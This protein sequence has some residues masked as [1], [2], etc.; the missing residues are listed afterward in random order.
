M[1][2]CM[3]FKPTGNR[4]GKISLL[5][6]FLTAL[7]AM[8]G[9]PLA[10]MAA[11]PAADELALV[12]GRLYPP[13]VLKELR[14]DSGYLVAGI[15]LLTPRDL[16]VSL[17]HPG[18]FREPSLLVLLGTDGVEFHQTA[19]EGRIHQVS[20][21][22][23]KVMVACST[24]GTI[25]IFDSSTVPI[26]SLD[27]QLPVTAVA[28]DTQGR[29]WAA[30]PL[31]LDWEAG[32]PYRAANRLHL[33]PTDGMMLVQFA[34][35][36]TIAQ[37][38]PVG[39]GTLVPL[40]LLPDPDGTLWVALGPSPW[41]DP[42]LPAP[43][44]GEVPM[45]SCL[46]EILADG[47]LGRQIIP[48]LSAPNDRAGFDNWSLRP[49]IRTA[50]IDSTGRFTLLVEPGYLLRY[51]REGKPLETGRYPANYQDRT[52]LARVVGPLVARG[53]SVALAVGMDGGIY[54][55]LSPPGCRNNRVLV[56]Q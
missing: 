35:D 3:N 19:V 4:F 29:I 5:L 51:S 38:F 10:G 42:A 11:Q 13:V 15:C 28:A 6:F 14:L 21:A 31:P 48:R 30:A 7:L 18:D 54:A 37:T 26:G 47:S 33:G 50:A 34:A 8:S 46:Q 43:E 20:A 49:P 25:K 9:S 2:N 22:G 56:I 23:K 40:A 16:V 53:S 39:C 24:D 27:A 17:V 36:G 52:V 32:K 41:L 45:P 12:Q 1:E 55:A 44:P